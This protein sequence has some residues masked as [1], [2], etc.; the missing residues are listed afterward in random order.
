LICKQ[1][2]FPQRGSWDEIWIASSGEYV[3]NIPCFERA[4]IE[5][6]ISYLKSD[7]KLAKNYLQ[8]AI[9]DHI[10]LLMAATAWNLKN[11]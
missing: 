6:I 3:L 2:F 4:A 8:G 1:D 5:P 9:G 7:F 10:N 11:G